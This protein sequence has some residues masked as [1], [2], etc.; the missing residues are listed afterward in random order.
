MS[1]MVSIIV[2]IVQSFDLL[3]SF[4]VAIALALPNLPCVTYTLLFSV[5]LSEGF[6]IRHEDALL[7]GTGTFIF[8]CPDFVWSR[9]Y[10]LLCLDRCVDRRLPSLSD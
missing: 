7:R 4:L 6:C 3:A 1:R 2:V 9:I 8:L 10:R 5:L